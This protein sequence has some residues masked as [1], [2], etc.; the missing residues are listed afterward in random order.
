[1][2]VALA[3][4]VFAARLAIDREPD[5]LFLIPTL[6]AAY[7]FGRAA[8]IGVALAGVGLHLLLRLVGDDSQDD[9]FVSTLLRLAFFTTAAWLVGGLSDR[10]RREHE[11]LSAAE[12]EL[13][14]LRVIREAL[15]PPVPPVRPGLELATAFVPAREGV[16][17]DFYLVT[18]G[19]KSSTVVAVGD[20]CGKG[21]DAAR[22]AVFV[23]T[24]LATTAPYS[25][26]PCNLLQLA[27]AALVERAGLSWSFVTAACMSFVPE[28]RRFAWAMAGHEAPLWLD[29]GNSLNGCE[30]GRV[31]GVDGEID[32]TLGE[33]GGLDRG[34][35]V[36]LFT[37]G[38]FEARRHGEQFGLERVRGLVRQMS[39]AAP[40]EIVEG[41]S[42]EAAEFASGAPPDDL[43]LV[44]L[45]VA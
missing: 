30:R 33:A 38:L 45:R 36:L 26:D 29:N 32:C 23:R 9:L 17:G 22:Q 40:A 7:W 13:A 27:N 1:V 18:E 4:G 25:E 12:S 41:L 8:G 37:D 20:V 10:S 39:G 44:A 24:A 42:T 15:T 16:S 21:L 31:L 35:G 28:E 5:F 34:Q 3:A 19:P 2:V 14:E 43:C 6:L 11:Q